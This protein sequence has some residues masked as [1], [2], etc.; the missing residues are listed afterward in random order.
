M[1]S[2]SFSS[3]QI[4]VGNWSLFAVSEAASNPEEGWVPEADGGRTT[5]RLRLPLLS[6]RTNEGCLGDIFPSPGLKDIL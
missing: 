2:P 3:S 1:S 5:R 4:R 6:T